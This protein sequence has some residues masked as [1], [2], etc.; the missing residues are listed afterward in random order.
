[1]TND[2]TMLGDETCR[3]L[4]FQPR[5]L[6]I[7]QVL[8]GRVGPLAAGGGWT[9][10]E[11]MM[12]WLAHDAWLG[13]RARRNPTTPAGLLSRY[14][15]HE[16]RPVFAARIRSAWSRCARVADFAEELSGRHGLKLGARAVPRGPAVVVW[17]QWAADADARRLRSTLRIEQVVAAALHIT[18][19]WWWE[20]TAWE[21]A[22]PD[23]GTLPDN[24]DADDCAGA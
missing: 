12:A 15:P 2:P 17:R 10:D 6:Q 9:R 19:G 23:A 14:K 3:D 7:T 24:D 1:V 11:A 22:H 21:K 5:Y 13:A 18:E 20:I 8:T 16:A 4:A